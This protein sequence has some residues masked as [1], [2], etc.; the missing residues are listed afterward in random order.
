[1]KHTIDTG[2]SFRQ[3]M[4]G[5]L[6]I[7]QSENDSMKSKFYYLLV[8]LMVMSLT[9]CGSTSSRK[10]PEQTYTIAVAS[11][12]ISLISVER[13]TQAQQLYGEQKIETVIQDGILRSYFE[14]GMVGIEWRPTPEDIGLIIRNKTYGPLKV[15]WDESRFIDEKGVSHKLIHSGVDYEARN[16]SHYPTIIDARGTLEDFVHPADYFRWEE[17]YSRRSHKQQGYWMRA[18]FLPTQIKGTAEE[19]RAKAEPLVGKTFQVIL[20]LLIDGVRNDYDCT[21]KINKVDVTEKVRQPGK[22]PNEGKGTR[23]RAF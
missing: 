21:F 4:E 5:F 13:P 9:S 11:Y 12:D 6:T 15:I 20:A 19:L 14:D 18:P 23:R 16:D 10:R 17:D 3:I 22:N 2:I 1:M 8:F 7:F